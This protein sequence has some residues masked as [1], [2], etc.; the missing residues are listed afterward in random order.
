M[1]S[2]R[3]CRHMKAFSDH[4]RK[5]NYKSELEHKCVLNDRHVRN[6]RSM[7]VV[8]HGVV[9]TI[10]LR[11]NRVKHVPFIQQSTCRKLRSCI[12]RHWESYIMSI[13]VSRTSRRYYPVIAQDL[14]QLV[15]MNI[16]A[17]NPEKATET[18]GK[19]VTNNGGTSTR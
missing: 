6:S 11:E 14:C 16:W 19:G 13:L 15:V 18:C 10:C 7:L 12:R 3:C 8:E 17:S 5:R 9:P 2:L 4:Q 1:S